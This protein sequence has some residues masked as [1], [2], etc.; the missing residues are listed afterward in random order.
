MAATNTEHS[1]KAKAL[2]LEKRRMVAE[3]MGR[4]ESE[5]RI[6]VG[7]Q[8][9]EGTLATH[10]ADEASDIIT[11]EIDASFVHDLEIELREID[12]AL[13]RLEGGTYG[14]CLDCGRPIDPARLQALPAASHC[15]KCQERHDLRQSAGS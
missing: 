13:D 3:Q 10:H 1:A 12:D 11:A 15:I 2:L 7:S 6:A 8:L 4:T 5:L 9:L 14:I